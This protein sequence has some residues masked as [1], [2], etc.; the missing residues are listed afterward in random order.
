MAITK[1]S[2]PSSTF[3]HATTELNSLATGL[4]AFGTG[5]DNSTKLH[6]FADF[7]L[8]SKYTSRPTSTAPYHNLYLIPALNGVTYVISVAATAPPATLWAG[9]FPV[10][11]STGPQR[12]WIPRVMLP[13]FKYKTMLENK[14]GKALAATGSTLRA[15]TYNEETA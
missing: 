7:E 6:R 2:T 13:P 1:W 11:T 10:Q 9:S 14:A 3:N 12:S 4:R 5:V 8:I 15:R